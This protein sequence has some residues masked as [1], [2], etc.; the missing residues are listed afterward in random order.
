MFRQR[1]F[2]SLGPFLLLASCALNTT[3]Q[4]TPKS[5]A[6]SSPDKPAPAASMAPSIGD[7]VEQYLR[8]AYAWGPDFKVNIGPIKPSPIP[9]LLEVP[10]TVS[11]GEQTQSATVYVDKQ[12][13]FLIRGEIADMS[14]DPLAEARD[15]LQIGDS[16][17]MGPENATVTLI[18][19]ADFEC[20]S[21]RQLDLI[22]RD[23][24]SRHP[25]ARLIFKNF[26]LTQ[27]H[28]WAMTAAIAAQ[29]AYHQSTSAF[30]KI[31]DAIYDAQDLITASNAS[32]KLIDMG[33]Q[34]NLD[35]NNFKTCMADPATTNQINQSLEEGRSLN[36]TG[37]PTTFVNARRVVGPDVNLINQFSQY[38][39]VPSH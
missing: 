36:V 30:W 37:T 2:L 7:H 1:S 10:F 25:E 33:T 12:A 19:F 18:E 17:S 35:M 24:M 23:F 34:L 9:D 8:N 29:C 27:I 13:R 20:P 32:D 11:L 39:S 26:P 5:G 38:K 31:H 15:K 4:T 16:P 22:L 6:S 3:A 28:P 21:C 14:V